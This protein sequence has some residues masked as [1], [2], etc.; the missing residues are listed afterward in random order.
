[1]GDC[2]FGTCHVDLARQRGSDLPG[3]CYRRPR[4]LSPSAAPLTRGSVDSIFC[5]RGFGL[6]RDGTRPQSIRHLWQADISLPLPPDYGA[7]A[8]WSLQVNS[9]FFG[10]ANVSAPPAN[11]DPNHVNFVT[12]ATDFATKAPGVGHG[13]PRRPDVSS[14]RANVGRCRHV[15]QIRSSTRRLSGIK[16]E[17]TRQPR[18]RGFAALSPSYALA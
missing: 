9:A 18:Y 17:P 13:Q 6:C 10:H 2:C 7:I 1:M 5:A 16:Q 4:R 11:R 8:E 14:L 12:W 3:G 15:I